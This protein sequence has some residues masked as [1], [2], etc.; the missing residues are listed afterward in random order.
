MFEKFTRYNR[1][2]AALTLR[3][4]RSGQMV[5]SQAAREALGNPRRVDLYCDRGTRMVGISAGETCVVKPRDG[6][7]GSRVFAAWAGIDARAGAISIALHLDGA[8]LVGQ[9]KGG[10]S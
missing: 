1:S 5:L 3:I 6:A 10:E 4:Y 8:M 9:V 2:R 7:L